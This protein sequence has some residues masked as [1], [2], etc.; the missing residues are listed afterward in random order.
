M[1]ELISKHRMHW[2]DRS[3][4][5]ST[6]WAGLLLAVAVVADTFANSYAVSTGSNPVK[7]IILSNVRVFDV[8]FLVNY[9]PIMILIL[10]IFVLFLR[11][12]AIPFTVKSIALF[13]IIRSGFISL[14][15][16]GQFEPQLIIPNS[17][18]I[19]FMGGGNSGGLFFSGHTGV[20]FLLAIIFWDNKILRFGFIIL[21]IVLGT[22]MLLAHLHYTIDVA[23]AFFITPSIFYLAQNFFRRDYRLLTQGIN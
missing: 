16:I 6:L 3:F 17:G 5:I 23:G 15:H 14:T 13:I 10:V 12:Q 18:F 8:D 4:Y 11:P 1:G 19:N 9:G 7:D 2:S 21:S 22:A 20:P